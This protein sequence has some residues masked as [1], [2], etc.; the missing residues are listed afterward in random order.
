MEGVHDRIRA[1]E[2]W[3]L[4]VEEP[5]GFDRPYSLASSSGEHEPEVRQTDPQAAAAT[6]DTGTG[7]FYGQ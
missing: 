1:R 6:W 7:L 2:T 5:S 4:Q 3:E